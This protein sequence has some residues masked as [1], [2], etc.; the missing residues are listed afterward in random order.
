MTDK[1]SAPDAA[2]TEKSEGPTLV[3]KFVIRLPAGLRD[4]IKQAE[5]IVKIDSIQNPISIAIGYE[6]AMLKYCEEKQI[7]WLAYA[8]IGGYKNA[9]WLADD[10]P[11]L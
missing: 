1:I 4:Q 6:D 7:A 3:E 11:I 5:K 9:E 10:F 2:E 8:P